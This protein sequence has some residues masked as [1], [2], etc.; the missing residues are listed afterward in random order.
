[1]T[2]VTF[3]IPPT[4]KFFMK[5]RE[6][7]A[8]S[9]AGLAALTTA[10]ALEAN[11]PPL[12]AQMPRPL[13]RRRVPLARTQEFVEVRKYTV[14]D[15]DKRAKLVETLDKALIPALNR[16]GMKPVGVFVP[17]ER[18]EKYALNVF[19]VIP[20][21][22]TATFV[23]TNSLLVADSEFRKAA[24]PMFETT[25]KDPLY[26]DCD[27]F[28]LHN[29][30]TM[31]VLEAPALG[32]D[33]VF[34]W[35][36]YR[37]FNIERNVAKIHMFDQGGELPL[38]RE[39]GLNPIFFGDVVAGKK[40]P[41]LMYLIGCPSLEKHAESWR[42]FRDHPKWLAM[43]DLEEYADTATEIDRVVLLPS[44]GSQI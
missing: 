13:S 12:V 16:Q 2:F 37:S 30:P 43:K 19:V 11:E 32:S 1:M 26:T 33:R 36:L 3:N 21:R 14:K 41:A 10:T 18:E 15:A 34:E 27:T 23:S 20:H 17:L 44:P 40:M 25:S 4:K 28:L 22:T 6:F 39:I 35:R 24:A 7:L 9:G 38:F 8:A 5:R 42:V 29:F 31:P